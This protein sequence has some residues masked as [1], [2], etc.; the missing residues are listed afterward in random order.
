MGVPSHAP[1]ASQTLGGGKGVASS[2]LGTTPSRPCSR[3]PGACSTFQRQIDVKE[4]L[5]HI[6]AGYTATAGAD[7][8][9]RM[10]GIGWHC[11]VLGI[12]D[13]HC[14]LETGG[15]P[16]WRGTIYPGY[17]RSSRGWDFS[18]PPGPCRP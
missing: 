14:D 8:K 4:Q 18:P 12:L 13:R 9:T 10:V 5:H 6:P 2:T 7:V 1:H 16:P 3:T 17:H 15:L 11:G